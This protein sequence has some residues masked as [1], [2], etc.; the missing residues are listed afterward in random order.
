MEI[1][2]KVAVFIDAENI[3]AEHAEKILGEASNYGDVIIKRVF[4]DWSNQQMK[5]WKDT[6]IKFSLKPEQQFTPVKGK[7]ASDI[8]LIVSVLTT[9]F[10]KEIDVFCLC[11]SDSDFIRLVQEL[12]EREKLVVGFGTEQ[13]VPAFVN[14]FSEFIYLEKIAAKANCL[15]KEKLTALKDTIENLISQ[16]GKASY[17]SIGTEMKNKFADFIPKN[18]GCKNLSEFFKKHL[19]EIGKYKTFIEKDGTTMSLVSIK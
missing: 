8:S 3:S 2:K 6:T 10:E 7:N 11:S 17:S 4:A 15:P 9:L 16:H 14:S 1:N 5:T 19:P 18:Y 12:R 13:T